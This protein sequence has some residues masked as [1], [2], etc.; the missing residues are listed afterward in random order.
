[1]AMPNKPPYQIRRYGHRVM[2]HAIPGLEVLA[3]CRR[4]TSRYQVG[5]LLR[6]ID[7]RVLAAQRQIRGLV[8]DKLR[9]AGLL[10]PDLPSRLRDAREAIGWSAAEACRRLG[11]S[12]KT[13][14]RWECGH[15]RPTAEWI[16]QLEQLLGVE[17]EPPSEE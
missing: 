13:L 6:E 16:E 15:L 11:I 7:H 3:V 14:N 5:E 9:R 12:R 4:G 10:E 8:R 2:V 1:M 17:L